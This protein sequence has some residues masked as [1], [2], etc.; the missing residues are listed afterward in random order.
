VAANIFSAAF[1]TFGVSKFHR[2]VAKVAGMT[3]ALYLF[4]LPLLFLCAAYMPT[5]L[6]AWMRALIEAG[7]VLLTVYLLS[8]VTENRKKQWR[9]AI[10][11]LLRPF[12][13]PERKESTA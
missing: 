7:V 1:L 3:F 5:G 10:R 6:P 2:P 13:A 12:G 8:F 9:S 4:H 11:W